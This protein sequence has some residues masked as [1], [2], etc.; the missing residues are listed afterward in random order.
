MTEQSTKYPSHPLWPTIL[1]MTAL[2]LFGSFFWW[3]ISFAGTSSVVAASGPFGWILYG[4]GV[5]AGYSAAA[6]VG[7]VAIP[8]WTFFGGFLFAK[9][10]SGNT[11]SAAKDMNV[12]FFSE[13]HPIA[14][15]TQLLAK[16]MELPPIAYVGWFPGEEINAF[17]VGNSQ[18]N[19]LVAV[20]KGAVERLT[21]DQLVAVL[22]HELGHVASND[23]ARMTQA[24]SIQNALTFY[25]IF[26]GLKQMVRWIFTPLSELELLRF[27]RAR[28]FTA[29]RISAMVFGPEHMIFALER[30]QEEER[31]PVTNGYGNVM[32]WSGFTSG[33]L[34]S[35]HPS[36]EERIRRLE[37]Y[38]RSEGMAQAVAAP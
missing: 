34:F 36:L 25:L 22:A 7:V 8:L 9:F 6:T 29:D 13:N 18:Y 31:Q 38:K 17:A 12:T 33:R 28:E 5:V 20:S 2:A 37:E 32:M 3:L 10:A 35:T 19:A 4:P 23:M 30:L 21:Q 16:R 24:R 15:A 1:I 11:G 26:R 14:K 27:S